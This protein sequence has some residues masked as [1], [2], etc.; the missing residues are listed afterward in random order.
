M[1]GFC[2][3]SVFYC[4]GQKII[5]LIRTV[6]RP[7]LRGLAREVASE[8]APLLQIYW[9]VISPRGRPCWVCE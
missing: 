8:A 4:P 2:D 5:D 3:G 6:D 7:S 9:V 1:D